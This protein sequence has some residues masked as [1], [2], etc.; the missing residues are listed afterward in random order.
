MPWIV[1]TTGWRR[2]GYTREPSAEHDCDICV[3]F[4]PDGPSRYVAADEVRPATAA[5]VAHALGCP[6]TSLTEDDLALFEL[7]APSDG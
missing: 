1:E 7:E 4:G 6:E 2:T 5:E 3:Q